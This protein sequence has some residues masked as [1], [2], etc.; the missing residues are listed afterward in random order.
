MYPMIVTY[1]DSLNMD[2]VVNLADIYEK[3]Q[4]EK[5]SE[6]IKNKITQLKKSDPRKYG[7]L[8]ESDF[9]EKKYFI[10]KSNKL[11]YGSIKNKILLSLLTESEVRFK[12]EIELPMKTY[13]L[14]YPLPMSINLVPIEEGKNFLDDKG[15]KTYR[16]IIHSISENDK[17]TLRQV[18]NDILF[19]PLN[20]KRA[21]EQE[22]YKEMHDK[23]IE[24]RKKAEQEAMGENSSLEASN[25]ALDDA[26]AITAETPETEQKSEE[27]SN[28]KSDL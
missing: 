13:R 25:E 24:E 14:E 20:E 6:L 21:K 2:V 9:R 8:N 11:S 22:E 10:K 16:G 27:N 23:I 15:T 1:G 17:K 26:S 12:S 28:K 5:L 19:S 18:V 3:R 7:R 4:D